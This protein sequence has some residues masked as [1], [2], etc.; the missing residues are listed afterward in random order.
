MVML[1][2]WVVVNIRT[3]RKPWNWMVV[4]KR[5]IAWMIGVL[6]FLTGCGRSRSGW[7]RSRTG[8]GLHRD[9]H[10]WMVVVVIGVIVIVRIRIYR[11]HCSWLGSR[12][13]LS[14]SC[15]SA[16]GWCHIHVVIIIVVQ[17]RI[18]WMTRV[19][20]GQGLGHMTL[21]TRWSPVVRNWQIPGLLSRLRSS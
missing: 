6:W 16:R 12:V 1:N 18:I 11:L 15:S 4:G 17:I 10:M 5:I 13:R 9:M 7:F 21:M 20:Y 2:S 3:V 19:I 8:S 14:G